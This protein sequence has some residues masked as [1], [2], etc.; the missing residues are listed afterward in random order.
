MR[1][2]HTADWHLGRTLEGRSREKEQEA[3]VEEIRRLADE[4]K[5][6]A[7]LIAGDVFDS[8]NPPA[9]AEQLF[10]DALDE[11]AGGG[12]RAVVVIAGNHDSP[13][14]LVAAAPL[15]R[16]H[17]IAL[18]GLPQDS[19]LTGS[20]GPV[21]DAGPS[22]VELGVP[23]CNHKAVVLALPYLSETR[24]RELLPADLE[25]EAATQA[26]YTARIRTVFDQLAVRF[27]ADTANVAVSH[28][29]V[30]GG[31]PSESE[32]PLFSV[33]GACTVRT[34][35]LPAAQYI[36]LGHLHRPQTVRDA[37]G[38]CRYAGSPLAHSFS[39]AGQAKSAVVADVVPGRRVEARE[40]FLTAGCPLVRWRALQGLAEVY[41][42]L[43]EGRDPNA[44]ID[45]EIHLANP[46][47]LREVH[48]LRQNRD[49]VNIRPVL[50]RAAGETARPSRHGMSV[51][52]MF[53]LFFEKKTGVPPDERTVAL[54]LEILNQ[55]EEEGLEAGQP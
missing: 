48:Q 9:A 44:W 36:A 41:R 20:G 12:R 1:F 10:Y 23:G 52:K 32:R 4:E 15:A 25:D 53:A 2:L 39:E 49:F 38:L 30:L 54:F 40:V 17:G 18:F 55:K 42:W 43:E 3:F 46:L 7:V 35:D 6:D 16:R 13:Q 22:W 28:L 45:L 5:V 50:A 24:A 27:R 47:S 34:A 14:R 51:D 31:S 8:V 21:I 11:L 26:A 37:A 29:F 33:G 19:P